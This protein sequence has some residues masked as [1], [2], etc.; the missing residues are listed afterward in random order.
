M[1]DSIIQYLSYA[2]LIIGCFLSITFALGLLRFPDFYSRTHAAGVADTLCAAFILLG[3]VLHSGFSLVT[4][5]LLLILLFLWFTS[6]TA[7][8]ALARSAY[9]AGYGVSDKEESSSNS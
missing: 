3:L 8:F 7:S 9:R 6:P 5:K 1:W 2:L 4:L